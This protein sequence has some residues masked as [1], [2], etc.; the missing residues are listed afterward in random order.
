MTLR[1]VSNAVL[2]WMDGNRMILQ[3]KRDYVKLILIIMPFLDMNMKS[4]DQGVHFYSP[5][6]SI[7]R[8]VLNS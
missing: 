3:G 7:D 5:D 1:Y 6:K 8:P 4:V 2:P